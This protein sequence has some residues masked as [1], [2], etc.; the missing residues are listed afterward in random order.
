MALSI[1]EGPHLGHWSG[2]NPPPPLVGGASPDELRRVPPK[3]GRGRETPA[4]RRAHVEPPQSFAVIQD[5]NA[6]P[7]NHLEALKGDRPGQHSIRINDQWRICFR[8]IGDHAVD[9]EIVDC[10]S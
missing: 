6:S 2:S 1:A 9:V 3:P 8:W 7:G 10:H 4:M 5:L